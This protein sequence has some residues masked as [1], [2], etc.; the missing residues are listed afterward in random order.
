MKNLGFGMMRLPVLNGNPTDFDYVQLN[1]MVDAF[2]AA[3]FNYFDTSFVYHN[4]KSEEAARKSLVERHPRESFRIAT[5]FPSFIP[6]SEDEV[7][8]TFSQQLENVGVEYFDYYL[9]H[10]LQTVWY[11]G[12]EGKGDGLFL[13]EHLFDHAKA[14]KEAGKIKHLGISFHSSPELLE[15]VLNTHPEIEFVQIALNGIDWDSD[16]VAAGRCYDIIRK[17]GKEV[18]VMEAVKG[19]GLAKLPGEAEK[20]LKDVCPDK[21]IASWSIRF[22]SQ[23]DGVIA[24]LSGMSTLDQVIDNCRTANEAEAFSA[25]EEAAFWKAMEIYRECTPFP[26]AELE[27]YSGLT[28]NGV[29]VYSILQAYSICLVQPDPSC[30]DDNNYFKNLLA[31]YSHLDI[32]QELPHQEVIRED[33]MNATFIV[34]EAA[35]YLQR[36]TF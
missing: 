23:L 18:I 16:F 4:G 25:A 14:W 7:E 6:M 36:H 28:W 19:G 8:K 24:V 5:K 15:R 29:S 22:A 34:E 35:A 32:H 1:K 12:I 21:S 30:I 9:L 13:S 3:G 31:E 2:L 33:G 26:P 11:D 20:L 10:N 27:K 17:H